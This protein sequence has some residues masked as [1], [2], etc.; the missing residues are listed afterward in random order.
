MHGKFELLSPG[1]A[2]RHN[3]MALPSIVFPCVQCFRVSIPP[4]GAVRAMLFFDRWIWNLSNGHRFGYVPHTRNG[5]RHEQVSTR[6]DS[7]GEKNCPSPLEETEKLPLAT[8]RDRNTT[9][10]HLVGQNN[11]APQACPRRSGAGDR[12][13]GLPI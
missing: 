3:S 7:E 2:N 12:T 8:R 13:Q 1:K 11:R 9:N 4:R 10:H 5:V 6:V